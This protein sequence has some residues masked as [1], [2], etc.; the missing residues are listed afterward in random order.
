MTTL[1]IA[2]CPLPV[3]AFPSQAGRRQAGRLA[4]SRKASFGLTPSVISILCCFACVI[5]PFSSALGQAA[6]DDPSVV[7]Y[8]T[9]VPLKP[10]ASS[11]LLTQRI[12]WKAVPEDKLDHKFAGDALVMNDRL[13]VTLCAKGGSAEVYVHTAR[14]WGLRGRFAPV[15]ARDPA[16]SPTPSP[17]P[18]LAHLR[19]VENNPGAVEVEAGWTDVPGTVVCRLTTGQ[20]FLEVRG[21]KDSQVLAI[22]APSQ[23]LV[24]PDFFGDDM[25]L[26]ERAAPGLPAPLPAERMLLLLGGSGNSMIQ[27]TWSSPAQRARWLSFKHLPVGVG[28]DCA[29]DQRVFLAF[30]EGA[31]LWRQQGGPGG[32]AAD[33]WK[34]P[35]PAKWRTN[36]LGADELC[37]SSWLAG[38]PAS[39]PSAPELRRLIYLLDRSKDTPL[40]TFTPID[41]MRAT[42]GFGPCKSLLDQE[43]FGAAEEA[44]PDQVMNYLEAQ[45]KL[46]QPDIREVRARLAAMT[47]Q[48]REV[49]KRID[50]Y[51]DFARGVRALPAR[52]IP[53]KML[54]LLEYMDRCLKACPASVGERCSALAEVMGESIGHSNDRLARLADETRQIGLAQNRCLSQCRMAVGRLRLLC[55]P[56]LGHPDL[57]ART[58]ASRKILAMI[59]KIHSTVSAESQPAT[60][61]TREQHSRG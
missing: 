39:V 11:K 10:L 14:G 36:V 16:H 37:E 22:T 33:D 60:M 23:W 48:V 59:Q 50:A 17:P 34:P 12:G 2:H 24:V 29:K 26:P 35:F 18:A 46:K 58:D 43:G 61:P 32:A 45:V 38:T 57:L 27:A 9:V 15:P 5:S 31:G 7:L 19:F 51:R 55:D 8:D 21:G 40:T 41:I 28:I 47:R 1:F 25:V 52:E 4:A 49:Q 3:D 20:T 13:A 56:E 42:L 53:D 54:P 30:F 44:T 6:G